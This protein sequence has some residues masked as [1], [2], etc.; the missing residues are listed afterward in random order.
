[1]GEIRR[2]FQFSNQPSLSSL[3]SKVP[4]TH[5]AHTPLTILYTLFLDT[6]M[7]MP[8][9]MYAV[10]NVKNRSRGRVG[11]IQII[12]GSEAALP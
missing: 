11:P 8:T 3:L 4:M 6:R 12:Q 5:Y 10:T 9:S 2:T 7:T 1:M